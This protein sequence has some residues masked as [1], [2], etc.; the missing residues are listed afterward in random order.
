MDGRYPIPQKLEEIVRLPLFSREDPLQI[1]TLW[2]ER[3]D[4]G[5]Q[6]VCQVLEQQQITWAIFA[7][8]IRL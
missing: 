1:R 8:Q 2:L 7:G 3:C 4:L 5:P 6:F